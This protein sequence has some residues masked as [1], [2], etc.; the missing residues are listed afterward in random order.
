M[1]NFQLKP[2]FGE[3]INMFKKIL[4]LTLF[5]FQ[6]I[7]AKVSIHDIQYTTI[8]GENNYY[9]SLYNDQ[10]VETGGI[11]SAVNFDGKSYFISSSKGGAWSGLFIYDA[12]HK[13]EIGDSIILTGD[14]YEYHGTTELK[15]I[16]SYETISK[17]NI[18]Q[19]IPQISTNDVSS[20]PYENCIVKINELS[21][22]ESYDSWDEWTVDDG[23]GQCK[24]STGFINLK[25]SSL[26]R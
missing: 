17:G 22:V 6:L 24:I 19:N 5:V 14:V 1:V 11:V 8:P 23:S 9:P 3:M 2:I 13:P 16:Q 15:S 25:S 26:S 21:V 4:I 20:E 10:T 7:F 12:S 18:L